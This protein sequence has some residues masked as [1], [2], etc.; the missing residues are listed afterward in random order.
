MWVV[1]AGGMVLVDG[2]LVGPVISVLAMGTT[3][4][5]AMVA[6]A[7]MECIATALPATGMAL[8]EPVMGTGVVEV[9]EAEIEG[10]ADWSIVEGLQ[11]VVCADMMMVEGAG[12]EDA[13]MAA[14]EEAGMGIAE[15]ALVASMTAGVAG[16]AAGLECEEAGSGRR[17]A[18]VLAVETT[19]ERGKNQESL[20]AMSWIPSRQMAQ[21]AS[22]SSTSMGSGAH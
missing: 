16:G 9:L 19:S 4:A 1:L 8:E 15:G 5:L 2:R 3:C 11:E 10:M 17:E 20:F 18:G 7:G 6:A 22:S 14:T 13:V 21:D 12:V